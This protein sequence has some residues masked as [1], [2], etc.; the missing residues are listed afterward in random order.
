MNSE[1]ILAYDREHVW[2][3]Y[4]SMKNPLKVYEVREAH[5]VFLKLA[6][7]REVIDGMSSWWAVVHGYNHPKINA[8][9]NAQV[10]KMSHVMFGG[11]THEGAVRHPKR[12]DGM[13][14]P[15]MQKVVLVS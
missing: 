4:A 7:G 2:H 6:D 15:K 1:E 11:L 10:A 8:A 3:P 14:P 13:T 9:I 12:H 5:G